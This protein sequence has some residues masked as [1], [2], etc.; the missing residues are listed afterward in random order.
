[1]TQSTSNEDTGSR[2]LFK[3]NLS[4]EDWIHMWD[5]NELKFHQPTVYPDLVKYEKYFKTNC[6]VL[7]PLCGKSLDL[8]YL[9]SK[10]YDVHGSELVEKAA[11]S[12]FEENNISYTK[13][14]AEKANIFIYKGKD[15]KI[16]IYQGDFLSLLASD[17]GKFDAV[18][19]R[20]AFVA[21][22]I[23][24]RQKYA[25]VLHDIMNPNC[26][27]LLNTF[28]LSGK[29]F[30]GPPHTVTKEDIQTIFG[31]FCNIEHIETTSA[32]PSNFFI[33]K[34]DSMYITN[35]LLTRKA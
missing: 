6:R 13:S 24:Q 3:G 18:W 22:N 9:E 16:T 30:I 21:I 19:D 26:K 34:A 32:N 33:S 20:A 1:M 15:K 17:V 35:S 14:K 11:K 5:I 25:E 27:Y 12:F 28:V 10:G 29:D 23:S 4:E 8:L 7:L 31:T 2:P